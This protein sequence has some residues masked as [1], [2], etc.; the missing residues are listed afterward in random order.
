MAFE[1]QQRV[2]VRHPVAVVGHA[3]HSL[4][5]LLDL[6]ANGFRARVERVFEQL[7][8]HRRRPL[9]HFA[10]RD[11]VRYRLRQYANA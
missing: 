2:V 1:S 10:R 6:D 11:L 3:N 4:A 5:A 9:D 7:L 8:H